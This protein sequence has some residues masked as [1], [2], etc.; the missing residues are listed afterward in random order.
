M[1]E[2]DLAGPLVSLKHLLYPVL[3]PFDVGQHHL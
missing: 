1:D 2:K 3:T